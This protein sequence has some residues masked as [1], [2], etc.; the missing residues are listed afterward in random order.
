MKMKEPTLDPY[1]LR[2]E[3]FELF[4]T[5]QCYYLVACDKHN[6]TYRVL[7]ID[8]TLIERPPDHRHQASS[9]PQNVSPIQQHYGGGSSQFSASDSITSQMSGSFMD[10]NALP[11]SSDQSQHTPKPTLRPLKD[12][13]TEDPNVY[14]Q[15]EIKDMLDMIHDGNRMAA[16]QSTASPRHA[17]DKTN[18]QSSNSASG[19]GGLKPMVKAYGIVGFIR[20][21][22]CYYLTLVTKRSKVG[23]LGGGHCIYTIK[24]TETIALKPA[25]GKYQQQQ[26]Q[27]Q[28]AQQQ[29]V[30]HASSLWG[31][32]GSGSQTATGGATGVNQA[33]F[34]DEAA[35]A[36]AA[37]DP[38]SVLLSM[39][40]RGKRSVGLGLSNREI[41]ELRY[42][43]LYQVVDLQKNFYFSYSYDLT[44]T[45]QENFLAATTQPFP[46]PPC[47]E[48]YS[49]NHFLTQEF[50]ACLD[51]LTSFYWIMPIIHGSFIQNKVLDYG[52]S[53][54]LVLMA[55]R[56]RHFAGTRYLKRGV[57]EEG[58]VANDVEHEQI[59]QDETISSATGVF[60]SYIQMRGSIPTFWTQESSVT[61]PK[62]PI[63]I[64]RVDPSYSATQTHFEDLLKRYS[65]PVIVLDLVKQSEK[66]ERE[67]RVGN[68]FRHAIDYINQ[69]MDDEHKI[70][71]CALDY[72]HISKH[73]NLDVLESLD[74]VSTW[75]VNMTGFF[76]SAPKWKILPEGI[77]KPFTE[78]DAVGARQ[79]SDQLGIPI[80]PLEQSGIL[81][82]NCIDCLDRTNVAQAKAGVDAIGHQLVVMGIRSQP[83]LDPNSNIVNVLMNMYIV[84]GDSIALQYGGSEAH[85]KVTAGKGETAMN[86]SGPIGKHKELL[87]SIR[88]YYSNAFTDRLK[89]DAMNL[90]LGYYIPHHHTIPLWEME[91]D[92]YL[93]N[94][95]VSADR[96]TMYSMKTYQRSFGVDWKPTRLSNVAK[97]VSSSDK[98]AA[99]QQTQNNQQTERESI[100]KVRS[101]C[102]LQ[103]TTLSGW[104]RAALQYHMQERLWFHLG[105]SQID[106]IVPSRFD[107]LYQPEKLSQ[108]DRLFLRDWAKPV[109]R[110]RSGQMTDG[111]EIDSEP[112]GRMRLPQENARFRND[113]DSIVHS[114]RDD[115]PID[116]YIEAN[117]FEPQFKTSLDS[118]LHHA[119]TKSHSSRNASYQAL[120]QQIDAVREEYLEYVKNPNPICTPFQKDKV[121]EFR[122]CLHDNA[123]P[124][125][126][127]TGLRVLSESAHLGN[128]IHSGPYSGL[129]KETSAIQVAT[130][131]HEQFNAFSNSS[132]RDEKSLGYGSHRSGHYLAEME[133]DRQ[134]LGTDGVI[135]A[136]RAGW[137]HFGTANMQYTEIVEGEVGQCRRSDLTVA[138]ALRLYVSSVDTSTTLSAADLNFVSGCNVNPSVRRPKDRADTVPRTDTLLQKAECVGLS[139]IPHSEMVGCNV[140]PLFRFGRMRNVPAGYE[141]INE[142]MF[143]KKDNKF[144]VL[145]GAG[146][147]SWKDSQ[148]VTKI[149]C[150]HDDVSDQ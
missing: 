4:S 74:D 27:A 12:F 63:E 87:T 54:N 142:D 80:F 6:S 7:K 47:K 98:V 121:A 9:N 8:R 5:N 89:Q 120:D 76:C 106:A 10:V 129:P 42:Q 62:P 69:T 71:Y 105:Q 145:N 107:I 3:R 50:E 43:G 114:Y 77:V 125:D 133:L 102:Q 40:N 29:Q 34:S 23:S 116:A 88:R 53:L 136:V 146:I 30:V 103:K 36:L 96:G 139:V 117:G 55:R 132:R 75:A 85:K 137:N 41:A 78:N 59:I 111:P 91:T 58:K 73:R 99:H 38:S 51:P 49:W 130:A 19:A 14:T 135:S 123:L 72:S 144:M 18:S 11:S 56:S 112:G 84:V 141:Q 140:E 82:T 90:F 110:S 22:D 67:V 68:E 115:Q 122:S 81:R 52:K 45:L 32:P 148:P 25:H 128:V 113:G 48:M 86:I 126:D 70:R 95:H 93:H 31:T 39:W 147:D 127:V 15:E 124:P 17:K 20:F 138:D 97:M 66:R 131:I 108:F 150:C 57:S 33:P 35:A 13:L 100:V 46:P 101:R 64:N 109:R 119:K 24:N 92:F 104:W 79:L 134:G 44:R 94:F 28:Y 149:T 83:K 65:Y 2:L 16:Q 37:A 1:Y 21:L 26:Q 143:A 61:M 60:S 118:F